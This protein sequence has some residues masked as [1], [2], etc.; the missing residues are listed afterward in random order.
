MKN[1]VRFVEILLWIGLISIIVF[2]TI[3]FVNTQKANKRLIQISFG[4]IDGLEIGAPVN[5]MGVEIGA[6]EGFKLNDDNILVSFSVKDKD[7]VI[8]ENSTVVVQFTGLVGAKTLEIEPPEGKVYTKENLIA[9]NPIRISSFIEII[10]RNSQSIASG[11]KNFLKLFGDQTEVVT[12]Q[13]M[14]KLNTLVYE[15]LNG[16][17][18]RERVIIN[19]R[20]TFINSLN[21]MNRIADNYIGVTDKIINTMNTRNYSEDTKAI[22]RITTYALYYFYKNATEGIYQRDIKDFIFTVKSANR[23]LDADNFKFF[24]NL[25]VPYFTS[26]LDKIDNFFIKFNK[27][28]DRFSPKIQSLDTNKFFSHLLSKTQKVK[29]VSE[30]LQKF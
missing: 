28:M 1:T 21:N 19:A 25:R 3:S 26:K 16:T 22:L 27:I 9:I 7:L 4:D 29:A 30:K 10:A 24:K 15:S 18:A 12:K 20:K 14:R 5:F 13:N 11:S 2:S 6:I 23:R 17:I 8:P